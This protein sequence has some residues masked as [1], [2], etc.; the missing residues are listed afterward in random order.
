MRIGAL[1]DRLEETIGIGG[2]PRSLLNVIGEILEAHFDQEAIAAAELAHDVFDAVARRVMERAQDNENAG[3]LPTLV[4]LG[5]TSDS[6]AGYC[7]IL[8][9]DEPW[10]IEAKK[11][12]L[13]VGPLL[14]AIRGLGYNEFER[15]G[16]Q[17][18]TEIGATRT[19]VTR[20]GNDQGIDFFGSLSMGQLQQF[21]PAFAKLAHDVVFSFVGQAKHY[22]DR[23]IGPSVVRELIG[24]LSLA[25]TK[26][27]SRDDVDIFVGLELKPFSPILALLFTTG[28]ITKGAAKLAE[29]AGII[30]RS[31]EQ[32]AMFLADRR[33]AMHE[34]NGAWLFDPVR[35][36]HWIAPPNN[37]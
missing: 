13:N 34:V 17:V 11:Q 21:P 1:V 8:P 14:E 4:I 24:S 31:G 2:A 23:T 6:I 37:E 18:L 10:Q 5:A 20:H 9:N 33:V 28:A 15:F 29:S 26:T 35:F 25:R 36:A 22:P 32:L 3:T 12:R 7:F 30:A 19:H 27:F 16:R